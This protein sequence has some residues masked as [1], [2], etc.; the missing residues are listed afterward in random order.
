MRGVGKEC[1]NVVSCCEIVEGVICRVLVMVVMLF[2]V[3]SL[4]RICS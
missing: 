1:C 3:F 2:S 4:W